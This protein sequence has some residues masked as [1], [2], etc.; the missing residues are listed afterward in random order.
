MRRSNTDEGGDNGLERTGAEHA[1]TVEFVQASGDPEM[2][3]RS[4]PSA[5]T[6]RVRRRV[7]VEDSIKEERGLFHAH[8]E[9]TA[10]RTSKKLKIEEDWL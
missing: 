4:R 2:S 6:P 3:V 7:A 1:S 5:Q 9:S 10:E 8:V